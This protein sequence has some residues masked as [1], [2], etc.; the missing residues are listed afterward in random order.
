MVFV[1]MFIVCL[2]YLIYVRGGYSVDTSLK[3]EEK[4]YK[5]K[6]KEKEEDIVE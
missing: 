6:Q 2:G 5:I 4:I 1:F 3:D